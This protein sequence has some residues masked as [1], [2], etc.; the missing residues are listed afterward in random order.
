MTQNKI[1]A[2]DLNTEFPRS[3]RAALAGYV[4]AG[5]TLDKCRAVLNDSAGEYHFA[6]PLDN[7]FFE[8]TGIDAGDF[9][10]FVATGADDAVVAKW[11]EDQAKKQSR[12][13]IVQWNNDLRYKRI[14]E[15]PSNLQVFLED[16]I[17]E[18]IPSGK[19]V[20]Y[21]FDVYDIEEA[22]I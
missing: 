5:R 20:Y 21:W 7:L 15:M 8:F 22:R 13:E 10:N 4:I 14:S 3:P 16:Y 2:L 19:V 12:E 17:A 1:K 9:K 11:I 6:C 18:N